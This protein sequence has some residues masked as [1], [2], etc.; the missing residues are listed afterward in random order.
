MPDRLLRR[1]APAP[2]SR[3]AGRR[4]RP[5]GQYSMPARQPETGKDHA[6]ER[7]SRITTESR[8]AFSAVM[9]HPTDADGRTCV[10]E[11]PPA[12]LWASLWSEAE[13]E[14]GRQQHRRNGK[15]Q[16]RSQDV[17]GDTPAT[18]KWI[19]ALLCVGLS[20]TNIPVSI[21][22]YIRTGVSGA[23]FC[24][25]IIM[26]SQRV[27]F[28]GAFCNRLVCAASFSY[29]FVFSKCPKGRA[30]LDGAGA[31]LIMT[32]SLILSLDRWK[33]QWERIWPRR[34]RCCNAGT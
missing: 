7:Q 22:K 25:V 15:D 23:A 11:C 8:V 17:H 26:A 24:G 9:A 32:V 29:R 28:L 2:G 14:I 3:G 5:T 18:T 21:H 34:I 1:N 30:G 27:H 6:S 33:R 16:E 4:L 10:A 20:T 13:P 19:D 31:E 12:T